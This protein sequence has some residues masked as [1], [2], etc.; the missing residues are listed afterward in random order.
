MEPLIVLFIPPARHPPSV[1][2][3][4]VLEVVV[5]WE[6]RCPT[7]V[8]PLPNKIHPVHFA[9]LCCFTRSSRAGLCPFTSLSS[10]AS[11]NC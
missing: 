2:R 8:F 11:L 4:A 9:S 5:S 10:V 7:I 6:P 3:L 1:P